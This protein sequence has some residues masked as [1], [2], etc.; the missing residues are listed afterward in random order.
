MNQGGA[1]GAAAVVPKRN[2][3]PPLTRANIQTKMDKDGAQ[4]AAADVPKG[5]GNPPQTRAVI[6]ATMSTDGANGAEAVVPMSDG[7]PPLTEA[8]IV[9]LHSS[10][11][12]TTSVGGS[13]ETD[14]PRGGAKSNKLTDLRR[15]RS[16]RR[17]SQGAYG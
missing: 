3:T 9:G 1:A 7:N 12:T 5:G 2:G 11:A 13:I 6:Q 8:N 4:G 15:R 17:P 14:L 16:K 10:A